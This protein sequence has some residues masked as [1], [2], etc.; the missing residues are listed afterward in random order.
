M[1]NKPRGTPRITE[2][3]WPIMKFLWERGSATAAE[4][5]A[6]VEKTRPVSMRTTKTLI[7]RLISKGMVGYSVDEKDS[8]VYHYRPLITQ[9]EGVGEKN[10][11][12]LDLVYEGKAG[13]LL[14]HFVE[15]ARLDA[16]EIDRLRAL[17]DKK[18]GEA[19]RE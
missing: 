7:R 14:A 11:A 15:N 4:I 10:Q 18:R 8:R 19:G 3:E 16:G 17:L 5:V 6:E 2:A 9:A 12:I 1:R 13:E